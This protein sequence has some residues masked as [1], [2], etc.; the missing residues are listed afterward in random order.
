MLNAIMP[1]FIPRSGGDLNF[2][3]NIAYII[4]LLACVLLVLSLIYLFLMSI[5]HIKND[6]EW[7]FQ[8]EKS[9]KFMGF[10]VIVLMVGLLIEVIDILLITFI[11]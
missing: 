8:F 9:F 5:I 6:S 4:V 7:V 11:S 2:N 10:S 3:N 1:I